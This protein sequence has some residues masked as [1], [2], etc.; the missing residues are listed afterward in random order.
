MPSKFQEMLKEQRQNEQTSRVGLKWED[1]EDDKMMSMIKSGKT[2]DEVA[3]QLHRTPGSIKTRLIITAINDM[4]KEKLPLS[5]VADRL[6]LNEQDITDYITRK[7]QR[8]TR[9]S[10]RKTRKENMPNHQLVE[11]VNELKRRVEYL[12]KK[13]Y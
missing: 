13:S 1:G 11:M 9:V 12:E 8:Q 3:L 2:H 10:V 6:F 7:E 4:E 5:E